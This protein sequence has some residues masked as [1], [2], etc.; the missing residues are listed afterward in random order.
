MPRKFVMQC[1]WHDE[2]TPSLVFN[3][4]NGTFHCFSC[5]RE[6]K[7]N[8]LAH[9]FAGVFAKLLHDDPKYA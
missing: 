5:G 1:L 2:K 7:T 8:D 3:Q 6:G 9:D 4:S